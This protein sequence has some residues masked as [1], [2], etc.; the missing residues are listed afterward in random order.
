M[1][2]KG[3]S[4]REEQIVTQRIRDLNAGTGP[5]AST[6]AVAAAASEKSGEEASAS[7]NEGS[8]RR[9][10]RPPHTTLTADVGSNY[11]A[12]LELFQAKDELTST[13]QPQEVT[14]PFEMFVSVQ[15]RL[16]HYH[17]QHTELSGIHKKIV[18]ELAEAKRET[19]TANRRNKELSDSA[20][21][22]HAR[23]EQLLLLNADVRRERDH[24]LEEMDRLQ[25]DIEDLRERHGQQ[26]QA[27]AVAL[28][29]I[30][31]NNVTI[32]VK[33]KGIESLLQARNTLQQSNKELQRKLLTAMR[34][35]ARSLARG[36]NGQR[37]VKA[38][39]ATVKELTQRNEE[40]EAD[41]EDPITRRR[42]SSVS[43]GAFHSSNDLGAGH[44]HDGQPQDGAAS[45]TLAGLRHRIRQLE[46]EVDHYRQLTDLTADSKR[47]CVK[48]LQERLEVTETCALELDDE[49]HRA[50]LAFSN[51]GHSE[52]RRFS[53]ERHTQQYRD[54]KL[55]T[56][57]RADPKFAALPPQLTAPCPF[58]DDS[59]FAA[60]W[61]PF[62]EAARNAHKYMS[63]TLDVMERFN[64][65]VG[66][67][68]S[69]KELRERW[70]AFAPTWQHECANGIH[71]A[72]E[73]LTATLHGI[74][75]TER[76]AAMR[77]MRAVQRETDGRRSSVRSL[78]VQV[79]AETEM[80][81][82]AA[83]LA[84]SPM[85]LRTVR[86]VA[87]A[88]H[89]AAQQQAQAPKALTVNRMMQTDDSH[90]QLALQQYQQQQHRD[91]IKGLL[92]RLDEVE[93]IRSQQEKRIVALDTAAAAAQQQIQQLQ[94]SP[95][96]SS[97]RAHLDVSRTD[98]SDPLGAT[99]PARSSSSPKRG[100][101]GDGRRRKPTGG[102]QAAAGGTASDPLAVP[103]AKRRG[104]KTRGGNQPSSTNVAASSANL[105]RPAA[106]S[107]SVPQPP[108]RPAPPA[109]GSEY[110]EDDDFSSSDSDESVDSQDGGDGAQPLGV[111]A[112]ATRRKSS[113][114][115]PPQHPAESSRASPKPPPAAP[116]ASPSSGTVPQA[117]EPAHREMERALVR[118]AA[119]DNARERLS[120]SRTT[121]EMT[122][123]EIATF[124]PPPSH[125]N[126]KRR[127]SNK[128]AIVSKDAWTETIDA[129]A[130]IDGLPPPL[131][132]APARVRAL[133]SHQA[134]QTN[135]AAAPAKAVA[136]EPL[137]SRLQRRQS[138]AALELTPA[139]GRAKSPRATP[140]TD[141]L[142]PPLSSSTRD[143]PRRTPRAAVDASVQAEL[144]FAFDGFESD[145]ITVRQLQRGA[146]PDWCY[147]VLVPPERLR[148]D[149]EALFTALPS[150]WFAFHN[151]LHQFIA[152]TRKRLKIVTPIAD[153]AVYIGDPQS[154]TI[155]DVHCALRFDTDALTALLSLWR[156]Q[157]LG[158]RSAGATANG[159]GGG[160]KA[161][162]HRYH[163]AITR[164]RLHSLDKQVATQAAFIRLPLGDRDELQKYRAEKSRRAERLIQQ[165]MQPDLPTLGVEGPFAL[166]GPIAPP[167]PASYA[168]TN[169]RRG[170]STALAKSPDLP[171]PAVLSQRGR[172]SPTTT[173]PVIP[174]AAANGRT[175]LV[176]FGSD[177]AATP[178]L[179]VT[180]PPTAPADAKGG[181][182]PRPPRVPLS[183]DSARQHARSTSN[184]N[185]LHTGAHE[186]P[187][188]PHRT[189]S[190]LSGVGGPRF[191]GSH[192]DEPKA[193]LLTGPTASALT[194]RVGKLPA[195]YET[196]LA[197]AGFMTTSARYGRS[198]SAVGQWGYR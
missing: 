70:T 147:R 23:I 86:E 178:G 99:T 21:A 174:S 95:S 3:L 32:M 76:A 79:H 25:D 108:L 51:A 62:V 73:G 175:R 136:A 87:L 110:D 41:D 40:D 126:P 20:T 190:T 1:S 45:S 153:P 198:H 170:S 138:G 179:R 100:K 161:A 113:I 103:P 80:V 93:M 102:K 24:K 67:S 163:A 148:E 2:R 15:Q 139:S 81:A 56:L 33:D 118:R 97:T 30:E 31:E 109:T 71:T 150:H 195:G 134:C 151:L 22:L 131:T 46:A 106:N 53:S 88:A 72:Y 141:A 145:G 157:Q 196:T 47:T 143:S 187:G 122:E 90:W 180:A 107:S 140:T 58:P 52:A 176:G 120:S 119:H 181:V 165:M 83:S 158:V 146:T 68:V 42:A 197:K 11:K 121:M 128:P 39:N 115:L 184:H 114:T 28:H 159:E 164:L 64:N 10:P 155:A 149:E 186:P 133:T 111:P 16:E 104:S 130:H 185:E 144:P 82:S 166:N 17:R 75:A 37:L 167:P 7:G 162:A 192:Q 193:P 132:L 78:G 117:P 89:A 63:M 19:D 183:L 50:M 101:G 27:V 77:I 43:G 152:E 123:E 49:L 191:G 54:G 74:A 60:L 156:E 129:P 92:L 94:P 142:A 66:E 36:G 169:S 194:A 125:P 98:K 154:R 14:V 127:T 8:P 9:P 59:P 105:A 91:E 57:A 135:D 29:K 116:A 4:Y 160:A 26:Q 18:D 61:Q 173:L 65:A 69:V 44:T 189:L 85:S 5:F 48:S 177:S 171:L 35:Q 13:S 137:K 12:M 124:R 34:E 172:R 112:Q 188:G 84:M 6:R 55:V 168:G 182:A 96:K 38:V